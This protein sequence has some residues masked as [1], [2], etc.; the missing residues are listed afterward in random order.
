MEQWNLKAKTKQYHWIIGITL[1]AVSPVPPTQVRWQ[2]AV[3]CLAKWRPLE[4]STASR[5]TE[6]LPSKVFKRHV[7]KDRLH[8]HQAILENCPCAQKWEIGLAVS[9]TLSYSKAQQKDWE[10]NRQNPWTP[11]VSSLDSA[12]NGNKSTCLNSIPKANGL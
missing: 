11:G 5:S 2:R 7:R 12:T 9:Q 4:D 10:P 1:N 3:Y 8:T 6:I